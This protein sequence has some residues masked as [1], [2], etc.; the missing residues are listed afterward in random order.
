MEKLY[1]K[2]QLLKQKNKDFKLFAYIIEFLELIIE[3]INPFAVAKD[4]DSLSLE[5]IDK[6]REG[7]MFYYKEED[8]YKEEPCVDGVE[9]P[10]NNIVF[11][12][13]DLGDYSD[14]YKMTITDIFTYTI[15]GYK[16]F[17]YT[18]IRF[19]IQ[20]LRENIILIKRINESDIYFTILP[21]NNMP[22]VTLPNLSI[23]VVNELNDEDFNICFNYLKLIK[24]FGN[25]GQPLFVLFGNCII[26]Y[27]GELQI[28]YLEYHDI[29]KNINSF[30]C[31]GQYVNQIND[32]TLDMKDFSII[33][34]V[35]SQRKLYV[36]YYEDLDDFEIYE[37][38]DYGYEAI[39]TL[40]YSFSEYLNTFVEHN[41]I[42]DNTIQD[43]RDKK[44]FEAKFKHVTIGK[45]RKK[46]I[47]Y[48][49]KT[50]IDNNN[51]FCLNKLQL[52]CI[53]EYINNDVHYFD[54]EFC[55]KVFKIYHAGKYFVE[56]IGNDIE[57]LVTRN[58]EN[59]FKISI[60]IS[61]ASSVSEVE[62]I[63]EFEN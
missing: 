31:I 10:N 43:C 48:S 28:R 12:D 54:L 47:I 16:R 23:G 56:F 37:F 55:N 17:K 1:N 52:K 51:K 4:F 63:G 57:V 14:L 22:D 8:F 39:H 50:F 27:T 44:I 49:D 58:N 3:Y 6:L 41:D 32:Y 20:C 11:K 30:V 18:H 53:N 29:N 26:Y 24:I 33:N 7:D 13:V 21:N 5:D 15:I 62:Y 42:I 61:S 35:Q 25:G 59:Q 19:T 45:F 2:L 36:N 9:Y 60:Q 34:V 46:F 40:I 38:E